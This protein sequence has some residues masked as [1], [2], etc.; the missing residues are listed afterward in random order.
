VNDREQSIAGAFIA[1]IDR[2]DAFQEVSQSGR[3]LRWMDL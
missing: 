1:M 3:T 2:F